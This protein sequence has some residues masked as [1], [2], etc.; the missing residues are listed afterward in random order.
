MDMARLIALNL[1]HPISF[2][3]EWRY[4]AV[5]FYFGLLF[6]LAVFTT[7]IINHYELP[8]VIAITV[9]RFCS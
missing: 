6:K 2:Y 8:L 1:M 9:S 3:E 5:I 7:G 4:Q